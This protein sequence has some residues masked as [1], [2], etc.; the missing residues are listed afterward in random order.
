MK[1]TLRAEHRLRVFGRMMVR[2]IFGRKRYE[3]EGTA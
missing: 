2:K 1:L 3:V